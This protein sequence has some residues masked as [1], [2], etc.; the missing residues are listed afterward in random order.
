MRELLEHCARYGLALGT[1]VDAVFAVNDVM[2]VGAMTA[3]REAGVALPGPVG[4]AGFDDIATLRDVHPPLTTVHV[5][6]EDVGARAVHLALG[7][8]GD[9]PPTRR[10]PVVESVATTLVLRTSTPQR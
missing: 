2:A 8:P 10:E 9:A 4:V 5:P 6:L 7:D 1:D 3:L